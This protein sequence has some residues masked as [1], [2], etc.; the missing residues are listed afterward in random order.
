MI[1]GKLEMIIL[2]QDYG[3]GTRLLTS[4]G[5]AAVVGSLS[6]LDQNLLSKIGSPVGTGE[7]K[8]QDRRD[9]AK[10]EARESDSQG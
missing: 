9:A 8:P 3:D 1:F 5:A 10:G 2:D 6:R 4:V 7:R